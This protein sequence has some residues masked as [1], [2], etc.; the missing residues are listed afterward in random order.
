MSAA[1]GEAPSI[2][3]SE[4]THCMVCCTR[5]CRT[6]SSRYWGN[7]GWWSSPYLRKP[8]Q[9]A[10]LL[11][12]MV[13]RCGRVPIPGYESNHKCVYTN[14]TTLLAIPDVIVWLLRLLWLICQ[15]LERM[16]EVQPVEVKRGPHA[17]SP[18]PDTLSPGQASQR[19]VAAS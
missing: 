9:D 4:A 6:V 8:K 17:L 1:F 10:I 18:C 19:N 15:D 13:L 16:E 3:I 12:L 11:R 14:M 2:H 7:S 5:T